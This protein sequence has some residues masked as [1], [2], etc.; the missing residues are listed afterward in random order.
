[1]LLIPR[2]GTL[3]G[4]RYKQVSGGADGHQEIGTTDLV[5]QVSPLLPGLAT[6]RSDVHPDTR[7][8]IHLVG[9]PGLITVRCT[10]S[11]IPG[12]TRKVRPSSVLFKRPPC[13]MPTNRVCGSWG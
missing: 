6:I 4:R 13:S 1:M 7:G 12:I 3:L 5:L 2:T 9:V 11:S 8:D 10:S